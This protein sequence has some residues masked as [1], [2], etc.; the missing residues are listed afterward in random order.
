MMNI[1]HKLLNKL[2]NL[3]LMSCHLIPTMLI[4]SLPSVSDP[5][6]KL[7]QLPM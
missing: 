4:A 6:V 3:Q 5:A 2:I 7:P 1:S